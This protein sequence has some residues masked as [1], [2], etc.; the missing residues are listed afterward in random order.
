MSWWNT[1]VMG[2]RKLLVSLFALAGVYWLEH[3]G[4]PLSQNGQLAVSV[5]VT[6]YFGANAAK[7]FAKTKT[8]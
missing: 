2:W 1:F 6:T 8:E 5:I 4:Y 7:A 3:S